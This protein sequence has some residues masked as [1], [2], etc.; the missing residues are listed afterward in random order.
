[1]SW[2]PVKNVLVTT[3]QDT[4]TGG[5]V[6]LW[7][8]STIGRKPSQLAHHNLSSSDNTILPAWSP[9]GTK[10]ALGNGGFYTDLNNS[11]APSGP[12]TLIYAGD[13]SAPV[14]DI[15]AKTIFY[16]GGSEFQGTAWLSNTS[17]AT[18]EEGPNFDK[19]VL[20]IW[21]LQHPQQPPVAVTIAQDPVLSGSTQPNLLAVSPKGSAI[22]V[23][24]TDGVQ[25]GQVKGTGKQA[26]WQ[27]L[28]P[29]LSLSNDPSGIGWSADGRFLAAAS[30]QT[31]SGGSLGIWDAT[32]N[33]AAAQPALDFSKFSS[34]PCALAWGPASR[35]HLL[36]IGGVGGQVA[37]WDVGASASPQRFL[38]GTVAGAVA[39]LAWSSDGQWLA[40]SYNDR[41]ASI[42]IWRI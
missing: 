1:M 14:P 19:L 22:A 21:D 29:A 37:L 4:A 18:L 33:Y 35:G 16:A 9:D 30:N 41:A 31:N 17:L 39:A 8:I 40:A 26:T 25:V 13:L 24:F 7:S 34:V 11:N 10:L 20:K 28:S 36:A 2:S 15:P 3:D 5:N 42:L 27:A 38:P 23:G 32:Q 12:E 6:V